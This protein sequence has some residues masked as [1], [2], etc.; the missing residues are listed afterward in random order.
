MRQNCYII[1]SLP[2]LLILL[3]ITV[4]FNFGTVN[5]EINKIR[6]KNDIRSS[7]Q[8]SECKEHNPFKTYGSLGNEEFS[9][10]VTKP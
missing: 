10:L 9:N 4:Q 1:L 5:F 2:N 8:I 7:Q 3:Y 6:H